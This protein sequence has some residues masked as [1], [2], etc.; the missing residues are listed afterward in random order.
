[1]V[2]SPKLPPP[3][4]AGIDPRAAS[5]V[6]PWR[7]RFEALGFHTSGGSWL[8]GFETLG[9]VRGHHDVVSVKFWYVSRPLTVN[10][11]LCSLTSALQ[12]AAGS[13]R[14]SGHVRGISETDTS[15]LGFIGFRV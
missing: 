2:E 15:G 13:C 12:E 7:L 3:A 8:F 10:M 11:D 6:A 9:K 5:E 1:M 14:A 4:T